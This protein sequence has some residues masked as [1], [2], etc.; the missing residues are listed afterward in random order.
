MRYTSTNAKP[1]C[2]SA[3]QQLK[4]ALAKPSFPGPPFLQ[5]FPHLFFVCSL[6]CFVS[7]FFSVFTMFHSPSFSLPHFLLPLLPLNSFLLERR[8]EPCKVF[9]LVTVL[10]YGKSVQKLLGSNPPRTLHFSSLPFLRGYF[11]L[12][13]LLSL[14]PSFYFAL[15]D[16]FQPLFSLIYL[17][18]ARTK[19]NHG[20]PPVPL[21]LHTKKASK[22][23]GFH[24][25]F[26][27]SL[28]SPHL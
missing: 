10:Q 28:S 3:T 24:G 9:G 22:E 5:G 14:F 13:L 7:V 16:F 11:S 19:K 12:F 18:G 4:R 15:F 2:D 26:S 1:I 21:P 6:F 23:S 25:S 17:S 8:L 20:H 27:H